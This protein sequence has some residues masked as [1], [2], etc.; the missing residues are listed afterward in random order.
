MRK[1]KKDYV[2]HNKRSAS[3]SKN[4]NIPKKNVLAQ[5]TP[6]RSNS[7]TIGQRIAQTTNKRS[8]I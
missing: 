8:E 7:K 6:K 2:A 4:V 5:V 3:N 1:P